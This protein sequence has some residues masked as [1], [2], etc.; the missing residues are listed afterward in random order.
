[1]TVVEQVTAYLEQHGGYSRPR[2]VAAAI[3]VSPHTAAVTLRYLY[4]RGQVDRQK[5]TLDGSVRAI[6]YYGTPTGKVSPPKRQ[7]WPQKRIAQTS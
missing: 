2:D 3:G 6:G 1:M 4:E 7:A 5:I